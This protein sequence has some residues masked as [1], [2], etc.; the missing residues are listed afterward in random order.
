LLASRKNLVASES[1]NDD[2]RGLIAASQKDPRQFAELYKRY[3]DRVYAFI[4]TRVYN[5]SIAEELTAH[6]FHQALANLPRFEWRG[7]GFSAWLFRIAA[8]ALH[9]HW[10]R[11]ARETGLQ[12]SEGSYQPDFEAIERRVRAFGM[13]ERLPSEQKQVIVMRF[14]E[15]KSTR[16]IAQAMGRSKGAIEQLQFRALKT[17]RVWLAEKHE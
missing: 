8:N 5:R 6:V 2:E 4:I 17:L 16:E 15:E 11:S 3:V 14:A 13:V 10:K 9:D 1:G 7:L 12:E